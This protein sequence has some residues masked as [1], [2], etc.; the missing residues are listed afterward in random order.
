M[1]KA[2]KGDSQL[3]GY[4]CALTATALWSGNYVVARGL[5]EAI[6]PVS[7]AT[8]RWSV[9][10][11]AILPFALKQL[12]ADWGVLKK[13]L[14]Y[15]SITSLLGVSLF[16]TLIYLAGRSTTAI[17]LSM[18]VSSFPVFIVLFSRVFLKERISLRRAAGIII[19]F[20]GAAFL[21]SKGQFS[22]ILDIE[23]AAGDFWVL[24][25]AILFAAYSILLGY[26]PD[27]MKLLPFQFT[28]FLLGLGLPHTLLPVGPDRPGGCGISVERA[29]LG[30]IPGNFRGIPVLCAVEQGHQH[31]RSDRRGNCVLFPA[32]IQRHSGG[33]DS[34]RENRSLSS[35]QHGDDNRG[36]H[37]CEYE[38]GNRIKAEWARIPRGDFNP[39]DAAMM[40]RSRRCSIRRI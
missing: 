26:R 18:I 14:P 24:L 10:S 22:R 6:S 31:H 38:E 1:K 21:I 12:I 13:H 17:N 39:E 27:G 19:V 7:L 37:N 40:S 16:N 15:L 28:T 36:N 20:A 3:I 2:Y 33:S 30:V 29:P 25:A 5:R 32:D 34:R 9:A 23:P 11:I 8:L 35:H 4:L